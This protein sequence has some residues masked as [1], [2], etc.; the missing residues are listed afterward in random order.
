MSHFNL[1][2]LGTDYKCCF[3]AQHTKLNGSRSPHPVWTVTAEQ[4]TS[5]EA[6]GAHQN[7]QSGTTELLLRK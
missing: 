6:K 3:L 7:Q 1:L 4:K 2:A 5:E